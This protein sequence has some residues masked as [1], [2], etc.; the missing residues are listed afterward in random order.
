[1]DASRYTLRLHKDFLGKGWLL[2]FHMMDSD[3][4]DT[5][6][7][8]SFRATAFRYLGAAPHEFTRHD[9]GTRFVDTCWFLQGDSSDWLMFEFWTSYQSAILDG[10]IRVIEALETQGVSVVLQ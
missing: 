5:A 1:M 4:D 9:D 3:E 10:V 6:F 7:G 8:D 2:E